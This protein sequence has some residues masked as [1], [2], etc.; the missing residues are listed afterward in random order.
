MKFLFEKILIAG[1]GYVGLP[2][3]ALF[4]SRK[5]AVIA[6]DIN[7][8]IVDSINNGQTHF[9]EPDLDILINSV[10]VDG[11]LRAVLKPEFANVYIIAVP[12]PLTNNNKPDLSYIETAARSIA[13]LLSK[14]ALV[15]LESTSPVGTTKKLAEWLS[16]ERPDLRFPVQAGE[17][18][19]VYVCYCPERIYPGNTIHELIFNTRVIGGMTPKCAQMAAEVYKIFM[20]GDIFITDTKTAELCKLAEN[21]FRDINIAYANELSIISDKYDVNIWEL[22]RLANNH[23]RVNILQPGCGVGGHCIAVDPWFIVDGMPDHSQLIRTARLVNEAK[24]MWVMQ[25]INHAI[26]EL[27]TQGIAQNDI[28]IA[29]LGITYKSNS[30]DIRESPALKIAQT[31]AMNHGSN[32]VVIEPNIQIPQEELAELNLNSLTLDEALTWAHIVVI[33]VDHTIFKLVESL[34]NGAQK[35]IDTRGIWNNSK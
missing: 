26:A 7:P 22:I 15:I 16:G 23:P 19:D 13:P 18:S 21:T 27:N 12:T 17:D 20:R 25:K 30:D 29:C 35:I 34:P 1:V 9:N 2:I 6:Y 14:G 3:G 33:L 5:K 28:R 32:L 31:L 10:S 11:Y 8:H 24:P 4:A